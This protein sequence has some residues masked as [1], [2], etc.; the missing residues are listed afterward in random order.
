MVL[1]WLAGRLLGWAMKRLSAGDPRVVL[2]LD[3]EDVELDFPGRNS[4]S[5]VYRG[6]PAVRAWLQR[7]CAI[8]IQIVPDEVVATGPPWD[9]TVCLRCRAWLPDAD[10]SRVYENRAVIWGHLRWGRL[11]RYEVYEDTQRADELDAWVT[12]HRPGLAERAATS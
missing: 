8:G 2:A 6:K 10:D 3:A 9:T 11:R 1:S 4:F 7:F 12:E 5:G